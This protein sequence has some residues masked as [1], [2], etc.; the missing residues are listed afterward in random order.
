MQNYKI[1]VVC[2][3]YRNINDLDGLIKT[4]D[5]K[6]KDYKLI[7]SNNHYDDETDIKIENYCKEHNLDLVCGDNTGYGDGNNRGIKYA[8]EN[9]S[10]DYLIICNSD[11]TIEK[12]DESQ[13]R[14]D[15]PMIFGPI[16]KT[17]IG[18][19]Q[20]PFIAHKNKIAEYFLYKGFKYKVKSTL[21]L[22]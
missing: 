20:N 3:V 22:V 11:L 1:V 9:Y 21:F 19:N 2:V 12:Y 18:K 5:E 10:F 8:K 13:L 16:I 6:V 4:L 17:K 7:I 14:N 15:K